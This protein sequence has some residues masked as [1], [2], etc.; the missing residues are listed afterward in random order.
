MEPAGG[1]QVSKQ[2]RTLGWAAQTAA[3]LGRTL[4]L[5]DLRL[6]D[7]G[8]GGGGYGR[9]RAV[10]LGDLFDLAAVKA[11]GADGGGGEVLTFAE[12]RRVRQA[13]GLPTFDYGSHSA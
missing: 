13:A 9:E 1:E 11:A 2:R 8:G 7:S 4:V 3:S 10:P 12:F 5:P 6:Y